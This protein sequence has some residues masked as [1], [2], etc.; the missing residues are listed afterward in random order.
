MLRMKKNLI[1]LGR[2]VFLFILS[3]CTKPSVMVVCSSGIFL[4]LCYNYLSLINALPICALCFQRI[5]HFH[6]VGCMPLYRLFI[7]HRPQFPHLW[8]TRQSLTSLLVP[9][10]K[11]SIPLKTYWLKSGGNCSCNDNRMMKHINISVNAIISC[12]LFHMAI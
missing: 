1:K 11:I 9:G 8:M 6:I 5:F 4:N 7:P 10:S 3:N 2:P 12:V